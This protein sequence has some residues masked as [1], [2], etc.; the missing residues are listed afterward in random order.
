MKARQ[1]PH[2]S[3]PEG[4]NPTPAVSEDPFGLFPLGTD[5]MHS[6]QKVLNPV[7]PTQRLPPTAHVE[8][9]SPR[10]T[11]SHLHQYDQGP[12]PQ[13]QTPPRRSQNELAIGLYAR[14]LII[15][16]RLQLKSWD[17]HLLFKRLGYSSIYQ[18][19]RTSHS[20]LQPILRSALLSP[21]RLP[22]DQSPKLESLHIH[23]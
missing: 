3:H 20:L 23:P 11:A 9:G 7:A 18:K 15:I 1:N 13:P 2:G 22:R 14:Q 12:H 16:Y 10:S 5:D 19:G 17:Q 8:R 6:I 4:T 21:V